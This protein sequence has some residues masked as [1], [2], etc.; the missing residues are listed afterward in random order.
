MQTPKKEDP[1]GTDSQKVTQ[2]APKK[3]TK[4]VLVPKKKTKE[5]PKAP[6]VSSPM[7][8]PDF[9]MDPNIFGMLGNLPQT[10]SKNAQEALKG[11]PEE[12]LDKMSYNDISQMILKNVKLPTPAPSTEGGFDMSAIMGELMK[13]AE[14]LV[15]SQLDPD[16]A[17]STPGSMYDDPPEKPTERSG[18]YGGEKEFRQ[19]KIY[20]KFNARFVCIES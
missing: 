6:K 15:T 14:K 12:Q 20:E 16:A 3:K 13:G 4:K 10:L 5:T 1:K 7:S 8:I 2:P 18:K 11:I 19:R 17:K 9:A